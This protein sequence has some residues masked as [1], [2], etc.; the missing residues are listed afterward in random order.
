MQE[1][2]QDSESSDFGLDFRPLR[3]DLQ[4]SICLVGP[5][6]LQASICLVGFFHMLCSVWKTLALRVREGSARL[7]SPHSESSDFGLDF[8]PLRRD[9]QASICRLN[10]RNSRA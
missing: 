10:H 3:R 5:P 8:R 1:A 2:Y 6:C 4:A 7:D 9:L